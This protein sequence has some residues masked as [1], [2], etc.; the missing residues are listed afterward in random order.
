[1]SSEFARYKV[2]GEVVD[3]GDW[4][5][6]PV[7]LESATQALP[8]D[9]DYVTAT[10]QLRGGVQAVSAGFGLTGGG[11][12]G[13]ITI[14]VDAT[15][16]A[17]VAALNDHDHDASDIVSGELDIARIPVGTTA[18]T[19]CRGDDGR[20][21][22][23]RN[24]LPLSVVSASIAP[25]AVVVGK[26]AANAVSSATIIAGAVLSEKLADSAVTTAKIAASAVTDAKIA[27]G[28]VTSAKIAAGA[29]G[30][31]QLAAASVTSAVI[32]ASAVSNDKLASMAAGLKGR[33]GGT[34]A[35]QDLSASAVRTFLNVADGAEANVNADW[36]ATTGDARILNKPTTMP[37]APHNHD[38]RYYTETEINTSL[39]AKASLSG[40]LF[41]G[42]VGI[43]VGSA[44]SP[45]HVNGAIRATSLTDGTTTKTVT[46][47]LASVGTGVTSLGQLSDV[48]ELTFWTPWHVNGLLSWN[49][50]KWV[51]V[52]D[53]ATLNW[54]RS[55]ATYASG[56]FGRYLDDTFAK[57]TSAS[58]SGPVSIGLFGSQPTSTLH[59]VGT[60]RA[61]SLTDGTTTK[62]VA[63][64]LAGPTYFQDRCTFKN[65]IELDRDVFDPDYLA[66]SGA[67]SST[68]GLFTTAFEIGLTATG[69]SGGSTGL[70]RLGVNSY[71]VTVNPQASSDAETT[72]LT[73]FVVRGASRFHG[74]IQADSFTDGTKTVP[75]SELLDAATRLTE[76]TPDQSLLSDF[77]APAGT[78]YYDQDYLWIKT[79][80]SG[81]WKKAVLWEI[82]D[83]PSSGGGGVANQVQL[84]QAQYNALPTKDPNTL[85][86]I[87]G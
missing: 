84:T 72:S 28:A 21:S 29:V 82:N 60:V 81:G 66:L 65:G 69:R 77:T 7:E 87:V 16:I 26:I 44:S 75:M 57:V 73:N 24:P 86:I 58:F 4:I 59:V 46:D 45:L 64:I 1:M 33:T 43:N 53:F 42:N 18:T 51:S 50:S 14:A 11:A 2:A 41:T 35:P 9:G 31:S 8:A 36:N 62:T 23:A 79:S 40:A 15:V 61:D 22:D 12:G 27:S 63:S 5:L 70:G 85:Y 32:A 39:A 83:T 56:T 78:M 80:N 49:G 55:V 3:N 76:K 48:Q 47:I 20:L 10:F 74:T 54:Q 13:D 68:I 67:G 37:P 19:V 52:R 25:N 30:T 34:G 17:T 6:V 71:G 38:D